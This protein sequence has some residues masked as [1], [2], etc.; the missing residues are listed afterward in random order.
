MCIRVTERYAVC[1]CVY[2]THGVDACASYGRHSVITREVYVGYLCPTHNAL[3]KLTV[4]GASGSRAESKGSTGYGVE[5][6]K[7]ALR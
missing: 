4:D 7:K 1:G 6:T 3:S 2:H 5:K